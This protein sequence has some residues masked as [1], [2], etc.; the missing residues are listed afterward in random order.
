MPLHPIPHIRVASRPHRHLIVQVGDG[1]PTI[2]E[3]H[4][5]PLL[6]APCRQSVIAACVHGCTAPHLA[7]CAS[8][9]YVRQSRIWSRTAG[10]FFQ[11]TP[12]H[13]GSAA[14]KNFIDRP[15][16]HC[17]QSNGVEGKPDP[18]CLLLMMVPMMFLRRQQDVNRRDCRGS[19]IELP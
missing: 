18:N 17:L 1:D 2:S 6:H 16:R 3:Q 11:S 5:L 4:L 7:Q 10:N 15:A 9:V 14:A 8:P 12:L 19:C 13:I